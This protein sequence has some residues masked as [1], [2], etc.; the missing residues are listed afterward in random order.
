MRMFD[1]ERIVR[2]R[3]DLVRC[4]QHPAFAPGIDDAAVAGS[5]GQEC[6]WQFENDRIAILAG[7]RVLARVD[8]T[9]VAVSVLFEAIAG[10]GQRAWRQLSL[11]AMAPFGLARVIIEQV[12]ALEFEKCLRNLE[13]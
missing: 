11:D 10:P 2:N 7:P 9:K 12:I 1:P 4:L 5:V 13:L 6:Q 3:L 8:E